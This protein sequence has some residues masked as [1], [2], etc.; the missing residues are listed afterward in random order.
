MMRRK[1]RWESGASSQAGRVSSPP[2]NAPS[3][4]K[5]IASEAFLV[6]D[7]SKF[8]R[9]ALFKVFDFEMFT[10]G[11]T[12]EYLDPLRAAQFPVPLIRATLDPHEDD[13]VDHR[14][15]AR[16]QPRSV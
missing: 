12:D 3:R 2:E 9:E 6:A 7:S 16:P 1:S 11:I 5:T 14:R 13:G 4:L 8:G 10:A 15:P